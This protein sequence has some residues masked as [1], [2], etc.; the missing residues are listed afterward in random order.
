M[1]EEVAQI[2][3]SS[4]GKPVNIMKQA[5]ISKIRS[6]NKKAQNTTGK[7]AN[8]IFGKIPQVIGVVL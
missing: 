3:Y 1:L 2:L 6:G 5:L 7:T 8:S 4:A